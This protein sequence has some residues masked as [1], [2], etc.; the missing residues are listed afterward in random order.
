MCF[1]PVIHQWSVVSS[2][3]SF[4]RF[5]EYRVEPSAIPQMCW[6]HAAKLFP[7]HIK[8]ITNRAMGA[9]GQND[10]AWTTVFVG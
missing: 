4:R 6:P 3:P 9:L 10:V 8:L 1:E 2:E 7:E 5:L